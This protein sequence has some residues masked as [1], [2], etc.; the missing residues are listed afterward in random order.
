MS[1]AATSE[2]LVEFIAEALRDAAAKKDG[3]TREESE[4]AVLEAVRA[5]PK[6]RL[7]GLQE[8]LWR[9]AVEG[10]FKVYVDPVVEAERH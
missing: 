1:D 9:D 4:V 8:R 10:F 2:E 7:A 5:L 3:L 6:D